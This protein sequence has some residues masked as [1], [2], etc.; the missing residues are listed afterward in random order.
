MRKIRYN[1]LFVIGLMLTLGLTSAFGFGGNDD[2]NKAPKNMGIL[3]VKT[4]PVAYP[5][6]IDGVDKGMTGVGTGAEIILE[7]GIHKLEIEFPNGKI[8]TK[9]VEII[10]ERKN[11]VCLKYIEETIKRPCPYDVSVSGPDKVLE[12][13][14]I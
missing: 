4:S 12:G 6:R 1:F 13:D 14:L 3:T 10:K 8:Y 7:P 5:V 11:C 2:K 9:D